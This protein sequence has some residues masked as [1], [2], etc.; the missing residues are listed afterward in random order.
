[1]E[2]FNCCGAEITMEESENKLVITF[3]SEK[4]GQIAKM[5]SMITSCMEN[6][7]DDCCSTEDSK[8][9]CC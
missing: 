6:C 1:M 8:S 9:S 4:S 7:G 2:K 3:S 5:K